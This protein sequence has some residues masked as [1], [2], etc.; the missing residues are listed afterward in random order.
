MKKILLIPVG[1]TICTAVSRVGTRAIYAGAGLALI[2]AFEKAFPSYA[3][4][5]TFTVGEELGILSE[6]MTTRRWD[7]MVE[8][9]RLYAQRDTFDG[10]VFA[11]GTDT[12]AFSA[13]LFS[14]LLS[15]CDIPVFFVSAN[16]PLSDPCSN[17]TDNF[18]CAVACVC[19][20]IPP[21]VYVPYKNP[22]TGRLFLHIGSRLRQCENYTDD[23]HSAGAVDV[24]DLNADNANAC[25]DLLE[26][27]FPLDKRNSG[28][29]IQTVPPL[30]DCVLQ[31]KPHVGLRYDGFAYERFCAVLHGAYH[32]GTVCVGEPADKHMS[33]RYLLERCAQHAVDVYISPMKTTGEVYDTVRQLN[34]SGAE[35]CYLYGNT[36]EIAYV[37]LLLAYSTF[38]DKA[39]IRRFMQTAYH[40]EWGCDTP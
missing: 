37:K 8:A 3:K 18:G 13:A 1:G 31:V 22:S 24:T 19:H 12:L 9:Y 6:N 23:F 14:M 15:D 2:A 36:N 38:T 20:G 40:Y 32:A 30:Q 35:I 33:I 27:R 25:F 39:D 29:S 7:R 28:V 21:R 26:T 17:G 34:Q 4:E 16:A 11:H 5:V 10:I